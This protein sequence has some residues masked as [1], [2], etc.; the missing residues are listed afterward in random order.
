MAGPQKNFFGKEGFVWFIGVVEDRNDPEKMGRLRVRCFGWHTDDKEQIST[1]SLPWAHPIQPINSPATYTAKEGDY[2]FGFFLDAHDAQSPV[3]VGTMA[4]KPKEKPNYEK[5]FSDPRKT[6]GPTSEAYP[7]TARLNEPT[8]SRLARGRTD[9]TI[10]EKRKRNL[11][12]N[13]KS[14]GGVTWSEPAPTFAPTYPYNYAHETESGHAFEL[15]DTPGKERVQ[16]AH[17][18]GAF[19]EF[20]ENGN[21]I[22]KVVKDNYTIIMGKDNV[23]IA[24]AC[25]ITVDG[26]CN[27]KVGGKLKV[28]ASSIEMAASGA[29]KMKGSE[30]NI[31]ATG[32]MNLKA[33]TELNAG[34]GLTASFSSGMQTTIQGMFVDI[35][36]A[37]VNLQEGSAT[38]PK[39]S[40]LATPTATTATTP[41]SNVANTA[42]TAT[43]GKFVSGSTYYTNQSY[44]KALG[45]IDNAKTNILTET[46]LE[47]LGVQINAFEDGMNA[48]S[49]PIL[50]LG[51]LQI[52]E[53]KV[54]NFNVKQLAAAKNIDVNLVPELLPR[55]A[56][57]VTLKLA[58][59]TYPKTEFVPVLPNVEGIG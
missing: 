20:D 17:K 48:L 5:G 51:D 15:D 21:R 40:G 19:I 42:N 43:S 58:K 26:A 7:L 24:G 4:G 10:I 9:G 29:I 34:A 57:L 52:N 23:Y 50:N 25:N 2:V 41:K 38:S 56:D 47:R 14:A 11:K 1:D 33:G 18:I 36:G 39:S 49:G 55:E 44:T 6:F 8:N 46:S 31:E 16:L 35:A 28:E 30:V 27:L 32:G 3:I 22:E 53:I 45:L 37:I 13:V 59:H 54:G 12:T